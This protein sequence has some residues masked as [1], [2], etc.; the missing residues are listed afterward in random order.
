M[1]KEKMME[2]LSKAIDE[3]A[4]ITVHFSQ[5]KGSDYKPVTRKEA[6][7]LLELVKE[8]IPGC[9]VEEKSHSACR[10]FVAKDKVNGVYVCVAHSP[11]GYMIEDVEFEG[12]EYSA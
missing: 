9:V 5:F 10:D 1:N 11:Q 8:A 3:G 6:E 7:I 2:L 12:G 4:D